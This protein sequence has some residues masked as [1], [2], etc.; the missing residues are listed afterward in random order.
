MLNSNGAS[1]VFNFGS[2][3]LPLSTCL[4]VRMVKRFFELS[5]TCTLAPDVL[6]VSYCLSRQCECLRFYLRFS[7]IELNCCFGDSRSQV[8]LK[9]KI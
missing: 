3:S 7:A 2:R 1:K 4:H 9:I 5:T 6:I 8:R